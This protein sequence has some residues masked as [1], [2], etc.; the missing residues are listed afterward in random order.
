MALMNTSDD[1]EQD[2]P[3]PLQHSPPQAHLFSRL[4][5]DFVLD[6]LDSVGFRG[7]GRLIALNS[8]ENRVYQVM[9]EEG[10]P[11]VVKFYRPD[12]WSDKHQFANLHL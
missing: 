2:A 5:P 6:A 12:R 8:Y 4:T 9:L 11:V 10:A 1:P 3:H 7:D